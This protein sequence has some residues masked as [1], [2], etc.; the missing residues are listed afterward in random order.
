MMMAELLSSVEILEQEGNLEAEVL[1]V[2][3]D[4]RM[5]RGGSVFV[6]MKGEKTDGHEHIGNAVIQGAVGIVLDRPIQ[7]IR[8]MVSGAAQS[9]GVVRVQNSRAT[10]G[11]LASQFHHHPSE[12]LQLIG[13]TGTNGKR[14]SPI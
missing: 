10:L 8:Q 7:P 13:V 6:A 9:I 4:S 11:M 12:H 1:D 2:T 3:D 5:V 14:P